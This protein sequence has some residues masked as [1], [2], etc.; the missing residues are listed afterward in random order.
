MS[1]IIR[2]HIEKTED[3]RRPTATFYSQVFAA[4][5]RQIHRLQIRIE[6]R[7]KRIPRSLYAAAR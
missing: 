3:V 2:R 7:E 5:P 4:L 6:K 1:H